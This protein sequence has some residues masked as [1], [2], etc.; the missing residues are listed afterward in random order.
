M[1]VCLDN[2]DV[3]WIL[4]N[5][6]GEEMMKTNHEYTEKRSYKSHHK[7]CVEDQPIAKENK[8]ES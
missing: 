1:N 4:K 6:E 2:N 8:Y 5:R 3:L 7:T